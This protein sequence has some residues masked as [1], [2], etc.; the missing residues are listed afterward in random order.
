MRN[1]AKAKDFGFTIVQESLTPTEYEL[2]I[3]EHDKATAG[4]RRIPRVKGTHL[5]MCG[6]ALR[7]EWVG[8]ENE[9]GSLTN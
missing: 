6:K 4:S 5:A 9:W 1:R 2:C 7:G 3:A 8:W